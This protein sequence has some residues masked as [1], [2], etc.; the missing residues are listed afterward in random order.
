MQLK[1][2]Q[3]S[4]VLKKLAEIGAAMHEAAAM[5]L[6]DDL[7]GTGVS[8][9]FLSAPRNSL[10]LRYKPEALAAIRSAFDLFQR[11]MTAQY[12]YTYRTISAYELIEGNNEAL[13]TAF[14]TFCAHMLVHSR[15]YS[16]STAMYIAAWPAAANA[17]QLRV[18]LQRL[19]VA[20]RDYLQRTAAPNFL[21]E[22]GEVARKTRVR[23]QRVAALRRLLS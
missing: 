18:G 14:A 10:L 1:G 4:E 15:M 23:R 9:D 20:A 8:I 22:D 21:K 7:P 6:A 2:L 13:S 3:L 19:V 17:Q 5:S 11:E 16:S 12:G